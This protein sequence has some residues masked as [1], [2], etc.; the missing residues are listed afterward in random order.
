MRVIDGEGGSSTAGRPHEDLA[1]EKA[2][3]GAILADN[4]VITE[5]AAIIVAE[6]FAH[7]AHA[8]IFEA[9][10]LLERSQQKVDHLTLAE[11]LKTMGKLAAIGGPHY[12]M[13]LDQ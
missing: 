7:P 11:Q 6:D 3:L 8:Q 9:M 10:L 2:V 1:A 13:N 12:L 4:P 5:I